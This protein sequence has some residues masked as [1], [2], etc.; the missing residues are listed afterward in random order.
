MTIRTFDGRT[1]ELTPLKLGVADHRDTA[2]AQASCYAGRIAKV[3]TSSPV[4]GSKVFVVGHPASLELPIVTEGYVAGD[5]DGYVYLSAPVY[6]GNSG[7]PVFYRG[8]VV[9]ILVRVDIRYHHIS[10]M[11]PLE[12]LLLRIAETR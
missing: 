8:E 6:G 9:G 10:L 11:V 1:C 7:G 2:T 12:Q 4:R 3:A 5:K